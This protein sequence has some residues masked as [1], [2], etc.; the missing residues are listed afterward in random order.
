VEEVVMRCG[1]VQRVRRMWKNLPVEFL[2]GH[3]GDV[4]SVCGRAL[5]C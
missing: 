3:F 1:K 2:N 4:C 5:S